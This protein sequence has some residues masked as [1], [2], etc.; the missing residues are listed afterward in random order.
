MCAVNP[1][2]IAVA[3]FVPAINNPFVPPGT[4]PAVYRDLPIDETIV[5]SP[6]VESCHTPVAIAAAVNWFVTVVTVSTVPMICAVNPVVIAVAA[7]V[8]AMNNPF[9]PPGTTP[10][11]YS[12]LPIED[13]AVKSAPV[14]SCHTPVAID[15]AVKLATWLLETVNSISNNT[16]AIFAAPESMIVENLP[17]ANDASGRSK[18][19]IPGQCVAS[20]SLN[21]PEEYA[22]VSAAKV[23]NVMATGVA[24]GRA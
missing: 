1:V 7:L 19:Y 22:V 20:S 24:F 11:V 17:D 9:V 5:K 6:A 12:D 10:D 4:T 13:V 16:G 3:A 23:A 18:R 21:P 15:A 2:V 8:P 14:A